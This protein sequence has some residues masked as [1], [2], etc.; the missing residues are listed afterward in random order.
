MRPDKSDIE[1]HYAWLTGVASRLDASFNHH[2]LLVL[3][4]LRWFIKSDERKPLLSDTRS[5]FPH[6]TMKPLLSRL[7]RVW[8]AAYGCTCCAVSC[9]CGRMPAHLKDVDPDLSK[10][11]RW[12][13]ENRGT[14]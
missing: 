9:T 3:R 4:A 11:V 1:A 5:Y 8:R 10:A 13:R 7:W 14:T 2:P 6:D 12:I